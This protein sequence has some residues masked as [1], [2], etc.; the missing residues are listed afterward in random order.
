MT[1]STAAAAWNEI[2]STSEGRKAWLEPEPEV[3]ALARE[4]F[5]HH[6]ARRA[7]DLGCG[8]G[9]H[10]LVVGG[11]G[12]H[13]VVAHLWHRLDLPVEHVSVEAQGTIR[14]VE[15]D[16]EVHDSSAHDVPLLGGP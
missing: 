9:R 3:A 8:L 4:R 14:V 7:L 6:G 15:R 16:L 12:G 5:A 10:A 11:P 1:N 13:Q 2:W